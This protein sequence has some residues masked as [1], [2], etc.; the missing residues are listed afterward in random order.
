MGIIRGE[1]DLTAGPWEAKRLCKKQRL[2]LGLQAPELSPLARRSIEFPL[3]I[4]QG[5]VMAVLNE[6]C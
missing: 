4:E 5:F 2:L 1:K 3:Q 6:S